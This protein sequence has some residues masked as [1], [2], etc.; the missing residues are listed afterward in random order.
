ME[1]NPWKRWLDQEKS[2]REPRGQEPRRKG[3]EDPGEKGTETKEERQTGTQQIR[4][5]EPRR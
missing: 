3:D 5:R 2:L 1:R 4:G